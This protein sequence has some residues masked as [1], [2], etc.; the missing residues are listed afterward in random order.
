MYAAC[1]FY[2]YYGI[3]CSKVDTQIIQS[4]SKKINDTNYILHF[5]YYFNLDSK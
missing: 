1:T 5:F 4:T 2:E 3:F